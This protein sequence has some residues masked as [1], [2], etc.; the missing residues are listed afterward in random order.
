LRIFEPVLILSASLIRPETLLDIASLHP[1]G[2]ASHPEQRNVALS[3]VSCK[4]HQI[5]SGV[6]PGLA[7][8]NLEV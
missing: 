8:P 4:G 6:L 7:D 3:L 5:S 2:S 1:G